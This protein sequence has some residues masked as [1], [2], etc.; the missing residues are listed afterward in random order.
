MKA[1]FKI[2]DKVRIKPRTHE[3][4]DYRFSFTDNMVRYVGKVTTITDASYNRALNTFPVPDDGWKYELSE[5]NQY[6]WSSGMLE[7]VESTKKRKHIK[8]NFNL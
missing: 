2:G 6:W 4:N 8:L 1:K 5:P 7:L 3:A